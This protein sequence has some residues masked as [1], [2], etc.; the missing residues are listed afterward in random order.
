M[1]PEE[2][3]DIKQ[4][5]QKKKKEHPNYREKVEAKEHIGKLTANNPESMYMLCIVVLILSAV[6]VFQR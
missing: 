1:Q 2:F 3:L 4:I 5:K 6:S